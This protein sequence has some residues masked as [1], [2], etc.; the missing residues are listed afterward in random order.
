MNKKEI[1]LSFIKCWY[2]WLKMFLKP[3]LFFYLKQF[4]TFDSFL[5]IIKVFSKLHFWV[6]NIQFAQ[7]MKTQYSHH[8][9]TNTVY[10]EFGFPVWVWLASFL[11]TKL[12]C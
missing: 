1:R 11:F 8:M 10:G 7:N 9:D 5:Q 12:I 4:A 2:E 6:K 3:S